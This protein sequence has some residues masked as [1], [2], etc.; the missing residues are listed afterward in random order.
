MTAVDTEHTA[1][2]NTKFIHI[3]GTPYPFAKLQ[4]HK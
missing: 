4:L 3:V 1:M 2:R